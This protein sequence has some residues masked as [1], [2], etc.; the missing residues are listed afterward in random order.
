[1]QTSL[2][3]RNSAAAGHSLASQGTL[4]SK[5]QSRAC[6]LGHQVSSKHSQESKEP[7]PSALTAIR[8][9][10]GTCLAVRLP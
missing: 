8:V 5:L 2:V 6:L 3:R 1:M 10:A 7:M 4:T 9:C